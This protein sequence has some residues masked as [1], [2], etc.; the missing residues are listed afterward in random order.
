MKVFWTEKAESRFFEI[1][2]Y[3]TDEFGDEANEKFG[4]KVLKFVE[5]LAA[6]PLLGTLEVKEFPDIRISSNQ[7]NQ[8][9]LQSI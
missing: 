4:Q 6:F 7:P 8:N 9:I 1:Q 2:E 3:I 5:L